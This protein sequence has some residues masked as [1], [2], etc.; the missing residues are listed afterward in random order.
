MIGFSAEWLALREPYDLQARN[1]AVL[2]S[3][4]GSL[5]ALPS[6]TIADLGCGTG[7]TLRAVSRCLKQRQ[8]WRLFDNDLGILARASQN[9]S[10]DVTVQAVPLDLNRDL[11]AAIDGPIDL[12][13]TSAL[14]DLVSD[15]WLERLVVE[16]AAR[17]IPF[18]AALSYDGRSSCDPI[19]AIDSAIVD[20]VNKHQRNDKGFGP[21]L[22]P[23]AAKTVITRLQ[24]VGYAITQGQADW[25]F[26][27][28]DR[29]IQN[30]M[31]AGWALAARE[32]GDLSPSDIAGWLQRR[33]D[34]VAA[35]RA[36]MRVGHVDVF[37]R[38]TATR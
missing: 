36:S 6:V 3:A 25:S 37:A 31:L 33:G 7:S 1:R 5:A 26:S 9:A 17:R 24:A 27:P 34:L 19:D 23:A 38:P 4:V 10:A 11:E 18:Y 16:I 15:E 20:A 8:S 12:V 22:G 35:G 2:D 13:T 21:A 32:T 29:A 30:E 14:L 28:Q